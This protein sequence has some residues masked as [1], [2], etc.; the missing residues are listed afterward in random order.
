MIRKLETKKYD[1]VVIGG[2]MSG[3]CAALAAAR[4]G[5]KTALFLTS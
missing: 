3:I 5:A 1:F 4:N 2:G